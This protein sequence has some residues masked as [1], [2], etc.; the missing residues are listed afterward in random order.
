MKSEQLKKEIKNTNVLLIGDVMLDKYVFGK[1]TRISPEAPV[2]VFLSAHHK[3]V[4]GGAGNVFNNFFTLG[5]K[6]TFI[7]IIG[8]DEAGKEVKKLIRKN[9]LKNIYIYEDTKKI[10]T[11]KT[12]YLANNQQ[13]I[14]VDHEDK[15]ILSKNAKNFII[16]N[17]KKNISS[18]NVVVISDYDKGVITKPLIETLI[19]IARDFKK[20]VIVDPKNKNFAIYKDVYL[21]TPNQLEASKI[22]GLDCHTNKEVE[23]CAN[24]IIDKYN[25]N[26]VIVTR[27]EKG[28]TFVNKKKIVHSPTR[29]IEVFDVSGA[30]DTVLA[31]LAIS[32]SSKIEIED[33]LF[34]AN[35]AAGIVVGKIG[36]STI[37]KKELFKKDTFHKKDKILN[38]KELKKRV[39]EDKEKDL[40]IGFTNGCF[41]I[42]HYGHISYLEKSRQLCDKLIVAINSD[43]SVEKLKGKN[44]P[45]NNQLSRAKVLA[46][47]HFCD[48]I[49]IFNEDTP[50]SLINTLRPDLITK[51]GDYKIKDVVG[52]KELLKW[53]GETKILPYLKEFSTSK[54]INK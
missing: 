11:K 2:P 54:I 40:R 15:I 53:G 22:T 14:R 38:L 41:D 27:G 26:N 6:S 33:V 1:V 51:G 20:P 44:R 7:T 28:L 47:L 19:K 45:I 31:I 46:A 12:R 21:V 18:C 39:L 49:I 34:Y 52:S 30:G 13:I 10:T 32:I 43:R 42:L 50:L 37:T 3:H 29:K 23:T 16:S 25:I 9:S 8:K 36:T 35:K 5:V 24:F 48:Y 17:F 4:L